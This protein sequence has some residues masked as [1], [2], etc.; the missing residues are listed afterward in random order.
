[1]DTKVRRGLGLLVV[2]VIAFLAALALSP[3]WDGSGGWRTAG[4]WVQLLVT[5]AAGCALVGGLV[6]LAW[7]L[8]APTGTGRRAS[9]PRD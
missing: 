3:A 8:L 4:Q 2:A 1:M 7:G 9:D 6:L 5:L